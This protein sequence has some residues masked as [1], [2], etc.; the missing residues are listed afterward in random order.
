M[1]QVSNKA[2]SSVDK[3]K[4]LKEYLHRGYPYAVI[5]SLLEKRHGV[6]VHVRMLKRKVRNRPRKLRPVRRGFLSTFTLITC[7]S[8]II[9]NFIYARKAS[10]IQVRKLCKTYATVEITFISIF[11]NTKLRIMQH[12]ILSHK[13]LLKEKNLNVFCGRFIVSPP[14]FF[15]SSFVI[16]NFFIMQTKNLYGISNKSNS[17]GLVRMHVTTCDTNKLQMNLVH[18]Q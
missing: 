9:L 15:S 2:A 11:L 10:Q 6:G 14:P 16:L 18:L 5:V 13:R 3:E 8:F 1:S 12:Q 7:R 4:L 17:V